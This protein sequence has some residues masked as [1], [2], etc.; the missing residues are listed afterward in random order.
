MSSVNLFIKEN[1]VDD[2]SCRFIVAPEIPE[3][4]LNHAIEVFDY[5]ESPNTILALF[6]NSSIFGL[7]KEGILLTGEKFYLNAKYSA[8]IEYKDIESIEYKEKTST[9][10]VNFKDGT[11]DWYSAPKDCL[12][13][14][15][16]CE[17]LSK[18]VQDFDEYKEED[19]SPSI[20]SK[21][22]E[23]L[24][25]AYL[26]IIIN[27]TYVNDFIID[28][29][30]LAEILLLMT[31]L[32]LSKKS[33]FELRIYLTEISH[34]N[35]IDIEE[36][37]KVI[38]DLSESTYFQS[39]M[40][41]LA[42]D[43][44][45]VYF[46]TSESMSRD[47]DFLIKHQNLLNL[48]NEEIDFAFSAVE[49]DYKMLNNDLDDNAI[50]KN[51]EELATKAVAV[52]APLAAVYISGSV[53]GMSAAGITSG[54]ATLGL[55]MGM[56]GGLVVVGLIGVMTYKGL[57]HL[58]G[59]N[60]RDKYKTRELMLHEVIKQT[61][62][63]ISLIID[64]I[65]YIIQKLNEVT[66]NSSNQ[67]EKIKKLIQMMGQFQNAMKTIDNKTNYYQNSANRLSC[68]KELD[69]SRLKSLTTEAI[70]KPL[71]NFIIENYEESDECNQFYLKENI[72]TEILDK[73]GEVFKTLGYFDMDNIVKGKIKSMLG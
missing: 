60:E 58:T 23:D 61:H 20:L 1:I 37:I 34:N 62:K 67:D 13:L 47:F 53:V 18:I 9:M 17:F 10:I 66:L 71:F 27:M 42:K 5:K 28:E 8:R 45:N 30:E 70:Q 26:K 65:N 39:L 51:A 36:A 64:D 69:V 35:L 38:K 50:K 55:G 52:G 31:R 25:I 3:K 41:S 48:S 15:E 56:T 63:T 72:D 43:L 11:N 16:L 57:K 59:A 12:F 73:M 21:M 33:R 14:G 19:Q 4:N 2:V 6:N 32:E 7:G 49:N 68:P 29:K 46:S 22:P 54:L 44:I 40:I 24:K